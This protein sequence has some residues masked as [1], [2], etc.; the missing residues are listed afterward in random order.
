MATLPIRVGH[1]FDRYFNLMSHYKFIIFSLFYLFWLVTSF[2][3]WQGVRLGVWL[4][5]AE[6]V[7][8]NEVKQI[9]LP[10]F[11]GIRNWFVLRCLRTISIAYFCAQLKYIFCISFIINEFIT[12]KAMFLKFNEHIAALESRTQ[13]FVYLLKMV[14]ARN[15]QRIAW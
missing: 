9:S 1:A 11:E 10:T 7:R 6:A 4:S 5:V 15:C 8:I 14:P 2:I 3:L 12:I 13:L